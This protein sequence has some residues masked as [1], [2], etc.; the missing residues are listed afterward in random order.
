M[1]PTEQV[2]PSNKKPIDTSGAGDSVLAASALALAGG[3]DIYN[4]ALLGSFVA[5]IQVGRLGNEPINREEIERHL[6]N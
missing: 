4:S 6:L 5:G 1:L 3:F 2:E